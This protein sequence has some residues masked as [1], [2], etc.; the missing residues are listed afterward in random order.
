MMA[1]TQSAIEKLSTDRFESHWGELRK[2]LEK[3]PDTWNRW[4]SLDAL[5]ECVMNGAVQVW[6]I[7][8]LSHID[9]IVFTRVLITPNATKV[10]QVFLAIGQKL[11]THLP[12]LFATFTRLARVEGCHRAE[13]YG[14]P[15]WLRKLKPLGMK[16]ATVVMEI[17]IST[18]RLH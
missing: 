13:V 18:E 9:L 10:L 16:L 12:W 3:V 5:Y 17:E 11:D 7:G 8:T 15:G 2:E 4:W 14:R 6:A 1:Q